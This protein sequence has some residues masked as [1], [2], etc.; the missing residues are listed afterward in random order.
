METKEILFSISGLL[1]GA[2]VGWI[3][4]YFIRKSKITQAKVMADQL[5]EN[6]HAEARLIEE[7]AKSK[8]KDQQIKTREDFDEEVRQVRRELRNH[9]QKLDQREEKMD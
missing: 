9:E 7:K 8:M 6:A 2:I 3:M 5:L 4:I 1:I